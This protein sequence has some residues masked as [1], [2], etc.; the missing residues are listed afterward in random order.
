MQALYV[1]ELNTN[2]TVWLPIAKAYVVL[3]AVIKRN[4]HRD[5]IALR[6]EYRDEK[7]TDKES[8]KDIE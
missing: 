3:R 6:L 1:N 7:S 4:R 5:D 8:E 2:A